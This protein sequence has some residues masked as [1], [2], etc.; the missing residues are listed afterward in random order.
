MVG[1]FMNNELWL[2]FVH[3]GSVQDYLKYKKDEE[4]KAEIVNADNNQGTC[5]Q[6]AD[7]RGE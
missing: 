3:T 7:N 2:N 6:R 1:D 4:E 5:Y